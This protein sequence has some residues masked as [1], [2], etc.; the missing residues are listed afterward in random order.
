MIAKSDS[1]QIS[2]ETMMLSVAANYAPECKIG[3]AL[4]C[5]SSSNHSSSI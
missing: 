5:C 3:V 2:Y 4:P 1:L